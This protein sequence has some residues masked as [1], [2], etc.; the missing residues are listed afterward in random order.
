MSEASTAYPAS[1]APA[2]ISYEDPDDTKRRSLYPPGGAVSDARTPQLANVVD[3]PRPELWLFW[4]GWICLP[5]WFVGIGLWA[6]R[7]RRS[8]YEL[9]IRVSD[10]PPSS[11]VHTDSAAEDGQSGF[12]DTVVAITKEQLERAAAQHRA[13][14]RWGVGCLV[15]GIVG[16]LMLI[17]WMGWVG[18]YI[19]H[20]P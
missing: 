8:P 10:V 9:V 16:C 19:R 4:F 5:L 12:E 7:R 18:W 2:L 15:M 1:P 3:P 6:V 17:G 13:A 14:L 20:D 11:S